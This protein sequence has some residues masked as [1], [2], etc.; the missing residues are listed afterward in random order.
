[1][2]GATT[3][4]LSEYVFQQGFIRG[5]DDQF[6]LSGD[7]RIHDPQEL[8][9]RKTEEHMQAVLRELVQL[10]QGGTNERPTTSVDINGKA[11]P[12]T[13]YTPQGR[14]V[15]DTVSSGTTNPW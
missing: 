3:H 12:G 10:V 1:M 7:L 6:V 2:S 8:E 13:P 9:A 5:D 4:T 11:R 14:S 15:P